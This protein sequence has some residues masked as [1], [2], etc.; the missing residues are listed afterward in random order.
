MADQLVT[1]IVSIDGVNH[2]VAAL[3]AIVESL[4][5]SDPL[6]RQRAYGYISSLINQG[7]TS[8]VAE[9]AELLHKEQDDTSS[10]T[11]TLK[12]SRPQ[13]ELLIALYKDKVE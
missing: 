2:E 3:T 5:S 4:N 12:W 13:T 7:T 8:A 10:S 6:T 1:F 9:V 11:E